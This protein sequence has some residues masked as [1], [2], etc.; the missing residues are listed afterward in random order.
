LCWFLGYR[1][2]ES[3]GD[4]FSLKAWLTKNSNEFKQE[5]FWSNRQHLMYWEEN[6]KRIENILKS[7][8]LTLDKLENIPKLIQ[9][10]M[11]FVKV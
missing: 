5:S 7:L 11:T 3:A 6:K 1:I 8:G 4:A 2:Y 10:W 9:P